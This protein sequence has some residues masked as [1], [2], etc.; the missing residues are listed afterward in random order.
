MDIWFDRYYEKTLLKNL[1]KG[2]I[3]IIYG[4]RRVGKTSLISQLL[5][6]FK[7][8]YYS[9]AGEDLPLKEL[10]SSQNI[11][12]MKSTFSGYD[13]IVIDEAQKIPNIGTGLKIMVDHIPEI[14][15]IA[16]GSS[17][18]KLS[19]QIGEPLTGRHRSLLLYPLSMMELN[20]QFGR[21]HLVS[22]FE[23][24]LIYGTYPEVLTV[25][26]IDEK[27]EYLIT[28]R[29]SY[30]FKDILELENI[31]NSDK[32]ADL[33]KML[34]FQIGKE[35][36][37][38]ELSNGLGISKQTVERYL[39]LL[40]KNFIIKKVRGFSRNL[41]KEI[42]KTSR[43]YFFDNGIRNA[44]ITNFNSIP[45]RND[46][47]MLWENFLFTERMKKLH[48]NRVFSNIYFWRTH[49]RKEIDLVEERDG[50]L[51]G[52]EFKWSKKKT[53]L[54]KLWFETY[55]NSSLEI[56]TKENFLDFIC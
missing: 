40:E 1:K 21:M 14:K 55:K 52:F 32:L 5:S 33:L 36:S 2:K 41:R 34:A 9:G 29:D 11:Q 47:G 26:N 46:V 15:I 3:V 8:K 28:L 13:L 50:K 38:N 53:K 4:P 12:R 24:Y 51:F 49:D 54:P 16:S 42:T 37:L 6:D 35:V 39:D 23:N 27:K 45:N 19:Y 20:N 43:Y 30:L 48:Y 7:G 17:S 10:F 18:F 44:L 56:I 31:R 22:M 25:N